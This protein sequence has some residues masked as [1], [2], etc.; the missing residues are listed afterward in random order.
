M[1][2]FEIKHIVVLMVIY[3]NAQTILQNLRKQAN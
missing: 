2:K 1:Q 3:L